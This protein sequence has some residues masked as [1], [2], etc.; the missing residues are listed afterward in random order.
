M[1]TIDLSNTTFTFTDVLELASE[2]NLVLET[3]DGR[4]FIVA[5]IDDFDREIEL[6]RQNEELMRFL[7]ERSKETTTY[8][9]SEVRKQL[10]LS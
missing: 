10:N 5:E 9:L 8:S 2:D 3:R 4:Q 7:D 6:I 1:K